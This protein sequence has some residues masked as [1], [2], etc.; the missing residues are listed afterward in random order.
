MDGWIDKIIYKLWMDGGCIDKMIDRGGWI[1]GWMD[2]C[3][4]RQN[5][6]WI[7]GRTDGWTDK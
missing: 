4:D 1:D 2:G 3:N 7:N 5:N 6:V